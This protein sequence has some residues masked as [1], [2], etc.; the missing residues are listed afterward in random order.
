MDMKEENALENALETVPM[1]A[2][3]MTDRLAEL[4]AEVEEEAGVVAITEV[5]V[6]ESTGIGTEEVTRLLVMLVAVQLD[7][8][9]QL[10]LTLAALTNAQVQT[11]LAT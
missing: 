4:A 6:T 3:T 11:V 2:L 8:A 5:V 10:C 1:S 9:Q 7:T